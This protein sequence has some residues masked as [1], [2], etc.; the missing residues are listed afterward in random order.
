MSM[1][2]ENVTLPRSDGRGFSSS[3]DLVMLLVAKK[4]AK[5]RN[6]WADGNDQQ[7]KA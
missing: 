3:H 2:E 1:L 5:E 6:A 4:P 7:V